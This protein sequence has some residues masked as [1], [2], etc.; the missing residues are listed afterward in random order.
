MKITVFKYLNK[1]SL[2]LLFVSLSAG[3]FFMFNKNKKTSQNGI[4]HL[5][6]VEGWSEVPY[7]DAA[8]LWTIGYGHLIKPGENY[9]IMTDIEGEQ[10]LKMDLKIA[11]DAVNKFV[12]VELSQNMFDALVSFVFNVGVGAFEDSTLLKVLNEGDYQEAQNQMARWN[13]VTINGQKVVNQGLV[14]RR[15]QEQELFFA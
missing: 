9:T 12:S 6:R 11:E 5:K 13:K 1:K 10:I 4:E 3:L 2:I 14:S 7:K 15:E 8:G